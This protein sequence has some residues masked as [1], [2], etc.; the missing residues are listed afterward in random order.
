M[1]K[2]LSTYSLLEFMNYEYENTVL[3]VEEF[4]QQNIYLTYDT[5]DAY[6]NALSLTK[7]ANRLYNNFLQSLLTEIEKLPLTIDPLNIIITSISLINAGLLSRTEN[8]KHDDI[9]NIDTE[10]F[11]EQNI[12]NVGMSIFTGTGVCKHTSAFISDL[13]RIKGVSSF[14]LPGNMFKNIDEYN[15]FNFLEEN[16]N[17]SI[18]MYLENNKMHLVDPLNL[19]FTFTKQKNFY[20]GDT[21]I[22]VP[23]FTIN[24]FSKQK[25]IEYLT[26]YEEIPKKEVIKR[27]RDIRKI[28]LASGY[29]QFINFKKENWENIFKLAFFRITEYKR[30]EEYEQNKKQKIKK[31]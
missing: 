13:L 5:Y 26:P 7:E 22:F 20:K 6:R 23:N 30:N 11:C 3:S 21:S 12:N 15:N 2:D 25:N 10:Y 27:I 28:M 17:H 19:I 24:Y 18:I 16:I 1:Q 29:Q 31:I 8:F 9:Y 4:Y 14:P